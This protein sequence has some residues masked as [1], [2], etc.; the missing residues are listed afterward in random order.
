MP[1]P[2]EESRRILEYARRAAAHAV[3]TGSPDPAPPRDGPFARPGGLFVTLRRR[4][5]GGLRG[6]IGHLSSERPLGET[7]A[8]V[9]RSAVLED[10]RF[11]PVRPDELDGLAVEVSLLGEFTE[12]GDPLRDLRVGVHGLRIRREGLGGILLPQVAAEHR[13]DGPAFLDAVCRKAGLPAGA[14]RDPAARVD[15]FTAEVLAE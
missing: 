12:T 5:D 10:P 15:L 4:A 6:C 11:P 1:L 7:L 9:A 14:W 3:R 2:P 13:L 8:E